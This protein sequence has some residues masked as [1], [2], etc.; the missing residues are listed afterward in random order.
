LY[1]A[2]DPLS[3]DYVAG[4]FRTVRAYLQYFLHGGSERVSEY[5]VKKMSQDGFEELPGG[6]LRKEQAMGALYVRLPGLPRT[7]AQQA[8]MSVDQLRRELQKYC[9]ELNWM[10]LRRG[11]EKEGQDDDDDEE[12]EV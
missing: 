1:D 3:G 7:K 11:I 6:A 2:E 8:D 9:H 4:Y 12:D 5:K 10:R